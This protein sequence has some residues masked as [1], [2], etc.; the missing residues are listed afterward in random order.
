MSGSMAPKAM[1]TPLPP[2]RTEC[3]NVL[4]FSG[5]Y[6]KPGCERGGSNHVNAHFLE[7]A[8]KTV[9]A[10]VYLLALALRSLP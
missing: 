1:F 3:E 6:R 9:C 4:A 8:V 5:T 10:N 7:L 2:R